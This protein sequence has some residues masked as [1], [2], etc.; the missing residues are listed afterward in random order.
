MKVHV[1]VN[2]TQSNKFN[3]YLTLFFFISC[4][5]TSTVDKQNFEIKTLFRF[6]NEIF[7]FD[8]IM[9]MTMNKGQ[10]LYLASVVHNTAASVNIQSPFTLATWP[11]QS[12]QS[13]TWEE[14]YPFSAALLRPCNTTA[15]ELVTSP[16]PLRSDKHHPSWLSS[17]D[18]GILYEFGEG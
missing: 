8:W 3:F 13:K 1:L 15:N 12:I 5:S 10:G 7:S 16:P 2:L 18:P 17:P 6:D 9:S 11:I 4:I 14:W